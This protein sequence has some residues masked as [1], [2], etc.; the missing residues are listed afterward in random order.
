MEI[1]DFRNGLSTDYDC[2]SGLS[3]IYDYFSDFQQAMFAGLA[4]V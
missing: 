4:L 3:A 1:Y 2:R